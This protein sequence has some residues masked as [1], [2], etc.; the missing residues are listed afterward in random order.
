MSVR[1]RISTRNSLKTGAFQLQTVSTTQP[2]NLILSIQTFTGVRRLL[3]LNKPARREKILIIS[4]L[5][6]LAD[7]NVHC[8][9]TY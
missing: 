3:S 5:C 4:R 1:F 7:D 9:Q 8:K 2:E 6:V